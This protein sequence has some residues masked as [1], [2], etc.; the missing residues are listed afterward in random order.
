MKTKHFSSAFIGIGLITVSLGAVAKPADA[1]SLVNTGATWN[2]VTLSNETVVGLGG[3]AASKTNNVVF[4]EVN[5]ESQ[6]RVGSA[7][8]G[9][10][11]QE[12]WEEET[13]E[14][15]VTKRQWVP[16]WRWSRRR[17][18]LV[19][20]GSYQWVTTTETKTRWVD[21]G[22]YVEPTDDFKSGLGFAGVSDLNLDVGQVFSVGKL[23]HFNQTI[24]ADGTD[25]TKASLSLD[26]DFSDTGLGTQ[27]FDFDFSIDETLNHGATCAYYTDEGKG[28]SD[29]IAWDFSI[30]QKN[31][32]DYEGEQYTLELVGFA[33]QVAASSIVND[34][35]SQEQGNNSANL[36]ARLVK[37]DTTQDIPEPASLL[38][39]AGL[40]LFA[41]KTRKKRISQLIK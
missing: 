23:T 30:D 20:R 3:E 4:R 39:L 14:K 22:W 10:T 2:N 27:S 41:L 34:F 12:N 13:Y 25:A 8:Y 38:G 17:G 19:D 37:V 36:F 9:W 5:G 31:A 26:L 15:E 7:V 29:R 24:W 18:K 32:F 1:F 21:N 35:I 28:C 33:E 6:V 40:G 11:W 16:D